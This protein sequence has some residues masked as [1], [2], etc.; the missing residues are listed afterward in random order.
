VRVRKAAPVPAFAWDT[1]KLQWGLTR[2]G[3]EGPNEEFLE[4]IRRRFNG[5]SPVRVRKDICKIC[6]NLN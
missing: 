6:V 2:E 1:T 3:E 5:A 4:T